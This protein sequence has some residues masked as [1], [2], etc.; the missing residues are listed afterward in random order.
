VASKPLDGPAREALKAWED[1][2]KRHHD[3]FVQ[4][5]RQRYSAYRGILEAQSDAAQWTSKLHPPFINHIVETTLAGL[6]DGKLAFRVRPKPRLW[7]PGEY[8][9]LAQ[10]AKAHEI[11]HACQLKQDR[12]NEKLRPFALQDAI[13]GLTVMKNYWRRDRAPRRRLTTRQEEIAPGFFVD[14]M[15]EESV[16]DVAFDGPTSEVVNVEDFFWHEAAVELQRSPVVAHRV[17]MHFHELKALEAAGVYQNVDELKESRSMEGEQLREVDSTDRAKDMIEVLEV[18]RRTADGVRSVTLG[19]RAVVLRSDRPNPFW[20]GEYPFVVCS[21]KPDLFRIPGMSQVEKIL[22]LQ[23]AHWDLE[24]QT[25]DNVRLANNAIMMFRSDVDDPDSFP[26]EPGA[27]W[28]VEDP[29]QVQMW[30]PN[31]IGDMAIPHLSRLEKQMQ[32]LAGS[33][34]FTSTSEARSVGADTATEAALITN[35]AQQATLKMKEQLNYAYERVGQQRTELNK[36]FIRKEQ[37]AEKVGIDSEFEQVVISPL[38]LQGDYLF[39]ITPMNESLMRTEKRA[40]A[41]AMLQMAAQITPIVAALSQV[42]AA[43][44]LNMDEFVRNWLE[45]HDVQNPDRFFSAKTPPA[46]VAPPGSPPGAPQPAG[47][48]G[49]T[50][51]ELA[52]SDLTQNPVAA[53][54]QMQAKVGGLNNA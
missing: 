36:Q 3:L 32:D 11:L 50:N 10:G 35:L 44:P 25:R 2:C 23:E 24:N 42:G 16:V 26:F 15:V 29:A 7:E 30:T 54:Q 47:E 33:Q 38:V 31:P 12:F 14:R 18:W 53:L 6:V 34:P 48:P 13:A 19:N 17:W 27:R 28:L 52:T 41:N 5:L 37:L 43:T 45:Q 39:D 49:V 1:G 9:H 4:K 46:G 8:E 21:T 20:H 51:P 40:E 22:H